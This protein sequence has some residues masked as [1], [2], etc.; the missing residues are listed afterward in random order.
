MDNFI[1]ELKA[2]DSA[3][4]KKILVF[5]IIFFVFVAVY[6]SSL[7]L[8]QGGM[9]TGFSILVL[10]F[11][12]ILGYMFWRFRRLKKVDYSAPTMTFLENA[13][14]RY[15]FMTPIDWVITIPL[16]ILLI[17]GGSVIVHSTFIRYF[18]V[19]YVPLIIYLCIMAGAVTVGFWASQ[20][21]WR[22]GNGKVLERI[23]QMK[24]EFGI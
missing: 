19:S 9:R 7:S 16:L 12:L 10:G 8:H 2:K 22:K 21:D 6:S 17:V 4:K 15:K 14:E 13:E 24:K 23:R 3:E 18:P 20:K 5:I 1:E 11:F